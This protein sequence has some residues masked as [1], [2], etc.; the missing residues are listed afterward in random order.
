ME[1][2]TAQQPL[3]NVGGLK[4]RPLG[5]RM[6][7]KVARDRDQDVPALIGVAPLAELPYARL[8][9]LIGVKARILA[10]QPLR[11]SRD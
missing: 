8:Q 5:R 4:R 2:A 6:G 11:E 10:E 7:R 1:L 9:H 3:R